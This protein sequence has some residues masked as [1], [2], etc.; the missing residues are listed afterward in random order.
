MTNQFKE[1]DKVI[2]NGFPGVIRTMHVGQL[3]GMADIRLDRGVVCVPLYDL[4]FEN[5]RW[6]TET[7]RQRVGGTFGS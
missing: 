5:P 6:T 4:A 2:C 1:G 3:E 7:A